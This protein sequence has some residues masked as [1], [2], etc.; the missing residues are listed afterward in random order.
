M[1]GLSIDEIES[2]NITL[3]KKEETKGKELIS[4]AQESIVRNSSMGATAR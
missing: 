2:G 4:Q 1:N 3:T